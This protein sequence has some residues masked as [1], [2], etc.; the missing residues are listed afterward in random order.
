M[1]NTFILAHQYSWMVAYSYTDNAL[2]K[3]FLCT[4]LKEQ[5]VPLL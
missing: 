4:Y 3:N 2:S 5:E 1:F